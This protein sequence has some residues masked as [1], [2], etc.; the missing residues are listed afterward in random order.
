M[1]TVHRDARHTD[2]EHVARVDGFD[3]GYRH[4][5]FTTAYGPA[6]DTTL[7]EQ[8]ADVADVWRA[9]Y[10]EGIDEFD[11]DLEDAE[12]FGHDWRA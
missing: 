2:R 7:P 10:A 5:N 1:R 12:A 6:P 11:A 4:R 8:F 9:A 3:A